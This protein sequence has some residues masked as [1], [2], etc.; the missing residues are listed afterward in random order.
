MLA[1]IVPDIQKTAELVSE[2][3]AASNEQNAGAEQINKAIQQLDKVIQ[4]NAAATEEMASTCEELSSQGEQL[5]DTIGFFKMGESGG[6]EGR[7]RRV[8]KESKA[9]MVRSGQ[10][11]H[12]RAGSSV[13]RGP[14]FDLD[15]GDGNDKLDAE[16]ERI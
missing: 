9:T 14:G 11:T 16:F 6:R 12:G 7:A 5:Q 13:V 3:N 10:K 15:L 4:E 1:K 2:I 8:Y